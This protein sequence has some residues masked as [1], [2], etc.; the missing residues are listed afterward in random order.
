MLNGCFP[1]NSPSVA[2]CKEVCFG[3]TLAA[4]RRQEHRQV[5]AERGHPR[6]LRE[7]G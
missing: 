5:S 3:A 7:S 4:S 6:D 2:L 1:I